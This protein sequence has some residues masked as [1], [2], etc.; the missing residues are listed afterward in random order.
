MTGLSDMVESP[1]RKSVTARAFAAGPARL[2]LGDAQPTSQIMQH[3]AA[4]RQPSRDVPRFGSVAALP[5]GGIFVAAGERV[6]LL[7]R[8]VGPSIRG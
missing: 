8:M 6:G 3:S 2:A 7:Q 4:K 1:T 5:R